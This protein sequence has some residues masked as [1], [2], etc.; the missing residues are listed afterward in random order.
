[1]KAINLPTYS[2]NL[3][4][5][6]NKRFIFD[7]VR[8]KFVV[9]TPEE[10]IRQNFIRYMH[11]EKNYPLSLTRVEM[12]VKVNNLS[13][14]CDIVFHN[15]QGKP[16]VIVECKAPEVKITQETFEQIA[17]YNLNLKTDYLFVTNG[18]VT[19]GCKMEYDKGGFLFIESIPD[20]S[21]IT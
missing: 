19:M 8:K 18:N 20:Y 21:D 15:R 17:R 4:S 6:N 14:R 9:L 16:L 12:G 2:F 11:L 3:K 5:E 10:W 1:M 13:R 7:E